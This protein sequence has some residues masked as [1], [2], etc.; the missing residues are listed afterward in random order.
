MYASVRLVMKNNVARIAVARENARG[1][2][3]RTEHRAR[4]ARA[5]AGARIGSLAPLQQHE[6]DD[7]DREEHV[8]DENDLLTHDSSRAALRL[9]RRIRPNSSLLSEAPPIRP[10]STSGIANSSAALPA[11]TLPP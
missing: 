11:F 4:C 2:A 3:A 7:A 8:N 5:E 9:P 6:A 1:R 10:P